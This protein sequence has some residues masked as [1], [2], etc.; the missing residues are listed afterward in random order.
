MIEVKYIEKSKTRTPCET[1]LLLLL[2]S[3]ALEYPLKNR[4]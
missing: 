4:I 2:A 1:L 3:P